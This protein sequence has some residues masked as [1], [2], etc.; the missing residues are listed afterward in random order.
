MRISLGPCLIWACLLLLRLDS[1]GQTLS[2][3]DHEEAFAPLFYPSGGDLVR[4]AS[5]SPGPGY[6]QNS[7]DYKISAVLDD[8]NHQISATVLITYRNNSPEKLPFLWL[9]LDQ[10]LFTA[11][12]RSTA[13][14]PVTG[15][16]WGNQHFDGGYTIKSVTLDYKNQ[17][18][19]ADYIINDTRMQIRLAKAI[20]AAGDSIKI[21]IEYSFKIPEYGA[22]R[23]GRVLTK[24]GWI[25]AIGQ[26]YPR[27][28]VFDN[29]VGWNT[30]PYLGQGEFYLEYGNFDVSITTSA[31]EIVVASGELLNPTEV[32]TPGQI[33]RLN[34][35]RQSDQA[36]M[37]RSASEVTDPAT[38]PAKDK[39][40]WHFRIDN[41]RD[42]AWA[43]STAFVWDAAKI[44]L[45]DGKKSLAMSLYPVESAQDL[46]WN[47][48]TEFVKGSIEHYSNQWFPYPYPV[49]INVATNV[50]GMEYPGIVFCFW[51]D[52]T[53]SLWGAT[54]HEF[55][56]TWFPMIVGSNE[57]KYAW[58]DEGFNTFLNSLADE[59]FHNGE[60]SNRRTNR[61]A[62]ARYLFP[63]N[64]EG[65]MV[66]PD[67]Y[68]NLY[69]YET[70]SYSKG[71]LGLQL[72]R[73]VIL[74]EERFDGAFRYYINSWAYKHPTPW[75]F[76]HAM[77]NYSGE[78]LSWFWRGWF[79]YNWKCDQ[80]VKSVDYAKGDTTQGATI[81]IENREKLPM[82][83][84]VEVK[85]ASGK[86]A[87]VN[88]PVEVW[89]KGPT[90]K[91][92]YPS[93][94][95]IQSVTIDPDNRLPD[96]DDSNNVW[97]HN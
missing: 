60:F 28:C 85:E 73:E 29:L 38:R 67:A 84:T 30:L 27:M 59:A 83:V 79:L 10:N 49:A 75:D 50:L 91:F 13:V 40:T 72:L 17:Q 76:F 32:L 43:A 55:G 81:T 66:I 6:W 36:V 3:Y 96:I 46:S 87:R 74:G 15:S 86:T 94:T 2:T 26:W 35:A 92:Y 63:Q 69:N 71:S 39:I 37:I 56:H 70:N 58:M 95:R 11:Q 41:A 52:Q 51:H 93:S 42:L 19:K 24:N 88:L 25:Y 14:T 53:R 65:L 1:F 22:D 48:S 90:W 18:E 9:Q 57:R 20:K 80:A 31:K 44:N 45:P 8:V 12:S 97:T 47:R 61:H 33:K 21:K 89:Q 23:M 62:T 54:S 82:P 64:G 34:Q 77:D 68:S 4:S 16:R 78:D 5:G 7:A